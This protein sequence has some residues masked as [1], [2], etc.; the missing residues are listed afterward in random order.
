MDI[1]SNKNISVWFGIFFALI[2]IFFRSVFVD[3]PKFDLFNTF[4]ENNY[5]LNGTNFRIMVFVLLISFI[6]EIIIYTLVYTKYKFINTDEM[7]Y[8]IFLAND[9]YINFFR[10]INFDNNKELIPFV[11]GKPK[12]KGPSFDFSQS[13]LFFY[14]NQN[15]LRGLDCKLFNKLE[16]LVKS[17]TYKYDK[18]Y[19]KIYEISQGNSINLL[20]LKYK[21]ETINNTD[22]YVVDKDDENYKN[23]QD[24]LIDYMYNILKVKDIPSYTEILFGDTTNTIIFCI[25][26]LLISY[27][28]WILFKF[29]KNKEYKSVVVIIL[30]FIA[31]V[32]FQFT[33]FIPDQYKW[34]QMSSNSSYVLNNIVFSNKEFNNNCVN[35]E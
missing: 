12:S 11:E 1:F 26:I 10:D 9:K 14:I 19:F 2:Y 15:K 25:G 7:I 28:L 24:L 21:K 3:N 6:T 16:E 34:L 31:I 18:E 13:S 29:F 5:T 30:L 27:S 20:N 23:I 33:K 4:N 22:I 17:N 32:L 8:S 35:K